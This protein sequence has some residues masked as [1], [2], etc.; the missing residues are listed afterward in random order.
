[1]LKRLKCWINRHRYPDQAWF[2]TPEWQAGEAEAAAEIAAG[3]S[4]VYYSVDEMLADLNADL[5]VI[6]IATVQNAT[7]TTIYTW[8]E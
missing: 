8:A 6:D 7:T 3:R 4:K 1:M 2:W 5:A